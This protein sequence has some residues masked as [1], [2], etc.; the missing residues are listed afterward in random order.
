[1][2]KR[3]EGAAVIGISSGGTIDP[4]SGEVWESKPTIPDHQGTRFTFDAP[5]VALND[6][7]ATAWGHACLPQFAG[8]RVATLALGTGVGAGFVAEGKL[9]MG[10][11]GQYP[12]L[13][14]LPLLDGRTVEQ[15]LGGLSLTSDPTSVGRDVAREAL[16][17][18]VELIRTM[19]FPDVL[20]VC[21]SV[22]LSDILADE[23]ERLEVI[24]SPFGV[25][26]GLMGA[27][28][29]VRYPG[30]QH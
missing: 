3:A 22:G 12:R 1:M 28:S 17:R 14:D 4:R 26:A 18:S 19:W 15:A 6:G 27:A 13:N 29:L 10:P 24:P 25:D 7:L 21:G 9:M 20:V 16:R 23:C 11:Y 2:K 30:W 5:T 8:K